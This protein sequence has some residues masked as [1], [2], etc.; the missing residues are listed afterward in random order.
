MAGQD[1]QHTEFVFTKIDNHEALKNNLPSLSSLLQS[2]VNDEP[3]LSSIGF[4]APLTEEAAAQYWL[5]LSDAICGPNATTYLL[6]ATG[7]GQLIA[8][9]QIF[10]ILKETHDYRGEVRKFLVSPLARRSGLGR[11]MA[12]EV[13]RVAR[14]EMGLDMLTLDTATATPARSFYQRLGWTEW[15]LCPG[16]AKAADGVR[17]DCSFFYKMLG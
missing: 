4:L 1:A 9:A 11:R 12:A 3:A 7:N 15:G 5:S 8:T 17:H 2:C 14:E 6:V 13:E 10:R 16:Y